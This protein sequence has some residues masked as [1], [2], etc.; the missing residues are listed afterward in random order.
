VVTTASPAAR[1]VLLIE[2]DDVVRETTSMVLGEQGHRVTAARTGADALAY[3]ASGPFDLVLLDLGLPDMPGLDL[4][5][6]IRKEWPAAAVIVIS[7]RVDASTAVEAVKLGA[8]DYL[9][10]PVNAYQLRDVIASCTR[11]PR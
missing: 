8:R 1:A 10:K 7:G 9:T 11:T 4:L 2:D 3:L 6:R 5:G